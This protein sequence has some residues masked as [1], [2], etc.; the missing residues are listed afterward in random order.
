MLRRRGPAGLCLA[1]AALALFAGC[2][3]EPKL[4][5]PAEVTTP[6]D[7]S[8][9][10]PLWAVV[11]LRNETGT[12]SADVLA[13]SD[14]VVAAAAQVHGVRTLP[15]NRSIAAMQALNLPDLASPAEAKALAKQLGVDGLLIGSITAYDPY[16]PPKL[17]I[18]LALFQIEGGAQLGTQPSI[19]PHALEGQPTDYH[20]FPR[21]AHAEAPASV[22]SEYLDGK[23]QGVQIELR[24]YAQGRTNP[25]AV[26]GWRRYLTSMDLYSEF[27]AWHAVRSLVN[28]EWVRLTGSLPV[29]KPKK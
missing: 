26:L 8:R 1:V 29:A 19:D 23:N 2:N 27:A 20:Y 11:P 10:E 24:D 14:K 3:S 4:V 15:L 21:S 7:A 6:Y 25:Q 16:D 13:I 22:V 9:S 28:R 18:A 17:G 5:P 12:T